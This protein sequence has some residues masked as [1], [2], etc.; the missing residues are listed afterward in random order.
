MKKNIILFIV[1]ICLSSCSYKL[2]NSVWYNVT[3][4]ELDG[5]KCNLI[6]SLYFWDKKTMNFNASIVKDTTLIVPATL[7]A[8]GQYKAKGNLR[9]GVQLELD[10]TNLL[11]QQ[12]KYVGIIK[13]KG[14]I[15]VYPDS[16]ARAFN[17]VSNATLIPI[18]K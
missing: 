10:V 11:N 2:T 5:T 16:T 3:P 1:A 13:S 9:K 18:K 7:T 4:T 12:E 17:K 15:L 6:T 14:M 8:N